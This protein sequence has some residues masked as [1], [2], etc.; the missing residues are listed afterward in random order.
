MGRHNGDRGRQRHHR[1][2][3]I[4]KRVNHG[5]SLAIANIGHQ[6][7]HHPVSPLRECATLLKEGD[8]GLDLWLQV[9]CLTTI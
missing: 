7:S 1:P 8:K 2:D 4:E 3:N 6:N 5:S 9:G